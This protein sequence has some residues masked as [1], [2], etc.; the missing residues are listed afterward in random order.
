MTKLELLQSQPEVTLEFLNSCFT[1]V[2]SFK[3]D[4]AI[5]ECFK[6]GSCITDNSV[7][8]ISESWTGATFCQKCEHITFVIYSDRMGGSSTDTYFVF[9]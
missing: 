4:K 7:R 1:Q 8:L 3:R 5:K 2:L 6:C 9:K